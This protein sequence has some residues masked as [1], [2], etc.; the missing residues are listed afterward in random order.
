MAET[1][2]YTSPSLNETAEI[3][4]EDV[5]AVSL[6]SI[7][8]ECEV[9]Y[10]GRKGAESYLAPG[11]RHIIAKQDGALKVDRSSG[12]DPVNWQRSGA[13]FTVERADETVLLRA[14]HPSPTEVVTIYLLD[15]HRISVD[16]G[17]QDG[18]TLQLNGTEEDIHA[19]I[20]ENP[21]DVEAGLR[22]VEHER[23]TPDGVIDFWARDA[24]GHSVVIE[25]KRRQATHENVQQL[26]RYVTR[27][28]DTNPNIRGILVAP[29]ISDRAD[30][31]RL[32]HDLE[33]Q[34]L[35]PEF[36]DPADPENASLDDF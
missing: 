11:D 3:L 31:V 30:N 8:A 16:A 2:T 20:E 35:S 21:E 13:T 26:S 14:R 22:I 23:E 19:Y 28:R 15:V 32:E 1:T 10:E 9:E 17:V 4:G 36:A 33:F 34:E 24:E 5:G 29:S 18:K 12:V 6:V 25:V 7:F 27:F